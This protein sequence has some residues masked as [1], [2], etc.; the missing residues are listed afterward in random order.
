[1]SYDGFIV[2]TNGHGGMNMIFF[3]SGHE[4]DIFIK[5]HSKPGEFK[6]LVHGFRF[7]DRIQ[8]GLVE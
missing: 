1:M 5:E 4:A 2:I 3:R 7:A 8:V 6:P